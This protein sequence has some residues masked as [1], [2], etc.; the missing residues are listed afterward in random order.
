MVIFLTVFIDLLGFGIVLPLLPLY[1]DQFSEDPGGWRIGA[2]MASY[3]LMQFLF[4]P[5]WGGISDNVGRRPIIILGITGSVIFYTLFA[6]AAMYKS[7]LELDACAHWSWD[8]WSD[9]S[10]GP[11]VY[12]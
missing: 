9:D 10:D 11:S 5:I 1:A 3:S 2:L 12:C 8:R 4:A 7:F 6:F